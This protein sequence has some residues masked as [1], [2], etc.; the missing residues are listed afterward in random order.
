[1]IEIINLPAVVAEVE[2]A[3]TAYNSALDAGDPAALN[4]FF[5]QS[6]ST[7][8]FGP[9]ENL[10][11]YDAIATYRTTAWSS[12][13]PRRLQRLAVTALGQDLATTNAVFEAPDGA[14][15]RQSQTWARLPA[16]WRIVAAHVSR[17]K[18]PTG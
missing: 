11:G 16:G 12:G 3:F 14:L 2:A 15:S 4:G 13:P 7:V 9:T 10:F 8:R 1:M 5:W 6:P 17:L 18:T